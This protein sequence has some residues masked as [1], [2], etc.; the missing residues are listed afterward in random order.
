M[1]SDEVKRPYTSAIR[2]EQA[3]QTR[4]RIRATA[5]GLFL[6]AGYGATS[7]KQVAAETG[8][9]ERTLYLNFPTKPAL[10]NEL[11]RVA[12][13]GHDRDEPLAAGESFRAVLAAPPGRVLGEIARMSTGLMARTARLLAIGEAAA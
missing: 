10:L 2:A 3:L 1:S 4:R 12:V 13:R 5:E 8:V 11:I 9:A 6:R 7:M